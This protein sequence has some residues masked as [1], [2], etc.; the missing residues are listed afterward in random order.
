MQI[1]Q[2]LLSGTAVP[3]N[4]YWSISEVVLEYLL[5]GAAVSLS[6]TE[7]SLYVNGFG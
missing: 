2:F 6:G 4:W 5:N 3:L 1:L 7:A